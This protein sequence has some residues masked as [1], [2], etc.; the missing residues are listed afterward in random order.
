MNEQEQA[1]N[2]ERFEYRHGML[3]R[4][5]KRTS[6]PKIV[7]SGSKIPESVRQSVADERLHELGGVYGDRH[8]GDPLEYDHIKLFYED[9]AVE[10]TVNNRGICLFMSDDERIKRIHRV[11][12]KIYLVEKKR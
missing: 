6:L 8:A 4:G 2:L 12:G 1:R 3:E 5:M 10:I 11:L 7:R 9:D